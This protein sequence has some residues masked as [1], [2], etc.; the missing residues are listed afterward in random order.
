MEE[1]NLTTVAASVAILINILDKIS[2]PRVVRKI[3]NLFVFYTL[4]TVRFAKARKR[5]ERYSGAY[6][7]STPMAVKKVLAYKFY[8][9]VDSFPDQNIHATAKE[10][11][12]DA[13]NRD[14]SSLVL[15]MSECSILVMPEKVIQL[16]K[17]VLNEYPSEKIVVFEPKR[18]IKGSQR[19]KA[20]NVFFVKYGQTLSAEELNRATK[21]STSEHKTLEGGKNFGKVSSKTNE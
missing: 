15:D 14:W 13:R 19:I 4:V 6:K 8:N 11:I 7:F 10:I 1:I 5:S 17:L 16:I 9:G 20:D 2:D 3:A 18:G 12:T 21:E